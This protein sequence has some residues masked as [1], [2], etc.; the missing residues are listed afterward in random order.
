MLCSAEAHSSIS[1]AAAVMDVEVV[2]AGVDDSG[3]LRGRAVAEALAGREGSVFA[4][5]ATAGTT[6]FGIVDDID[7]IADVAAEHGIWLHV[8]AD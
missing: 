2:P 1:S 4:I 6:N 5:V 7:S 3:R 8:D